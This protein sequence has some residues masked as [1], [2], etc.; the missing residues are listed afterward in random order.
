M[1]YNNSMKKGRR[2]GF[3]IIEVALFLAI[4]GAIFVAVMVNTASTVARRRYSDTVNDAVEIIREAY[5]ATINVENY[6]KKTD[7][8][9]FWCST[10]SAF[11]GGFHRDSDSTSAKI[12]NYPGRTRCAIYGQLLVFDEPNTNDS[13]DTD[14]YIYRYTV[15]GRAVDNNIEPTGMDEVL[16][17]LKTVA[18]NVVTM[19]QIDNSAVNCNAAL[20]G[21][22]TSHSLQWGG[23]LENR[24]DRNPYRGAILI[25]RSPISA[26]VHTYIYSQY[27][28]V[29]KDNPINDTTFSIQD[30]LHTTP[31]SACNSTAFSNAASRFVQAPITS[32]KWI[33]NQ[34]LD[35]CVGSD[36]L[37]SV[38]NRRRAIRIHG[39]GSNES[40]VELLT[41]AESALVCEEV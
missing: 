39:D 38:G 34:D 14:S 29:S 16:N 33:K 21:N 18:A 28:D 19:K 23:R 5:S 12:D 7:D 22:Y 17:S 24:K 37:Q 8:A 40:A 41:E 11:N 9:S 10:T 31:T 32:N 3:T 26:T 1:R 2:K 20:A 6:R 35:L 13:S 30:W 4:T 15:I 36:D 27:K 25:A